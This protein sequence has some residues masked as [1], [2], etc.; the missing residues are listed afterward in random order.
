MTKIKER[1]MGD[2][3]DQITELFAAPRGQ[4]ELVVTIGGVKIYSSPSLKQNFLKAMSKSS[5]VAPI[6]KTVEK[7]IDKGEFIPCYLT[8]KIVKTIL[9][10]QPPEFKGYA[11]TTFGQYILVYVDNDTNIFGFASNNELSITTLHELI[12]KASNKFSKQ[13]FNAFVSEMTVFYHFYWSRIFSLDQKKLNVKDIKEIISFLYF[14][15]EKHGERND[16]KVLNQYYSLLH[17]KLKPASTLDDAEIDKLI[18]DY[19]V[20]IKIIW[21]ASKSHAPALI[22]KATYANKHLIAP[23]YTAYKVAFG[24]NVRQI[25]ELCYQELFFPSEVIS[26]PALLK[27]PSAKVYSIVNKL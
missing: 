20:L 9:R 26:L 17:E 27:R 24:I 15:I 23:L 13:F 18:Q 25:A 3:I 4:L 8:D 21:K 12:H 1:D 10:R 5:R 22:D 14:N 11:G 2:Q 19:I 6:V 7:L 16:N